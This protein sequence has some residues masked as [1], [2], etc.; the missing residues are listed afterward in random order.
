ML[1]MSARKKVKTISAKS[2]AVTHAAS[3]TDCKDRNRA[4]TQD[5]TGAQRRSALQEAAVA[6]SGTRVTGG[7]PVSPLGQP[8]AKRSAGVAG[9]TEPDDRGADSNHRAG[10]GEMSGGAA[11]EDASRSRIADRANGGV[12]TS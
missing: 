12:R 7:V 5:R 3:L 4:C 2:T 8:A 1:A 6:G 9:P 10:S 11:L